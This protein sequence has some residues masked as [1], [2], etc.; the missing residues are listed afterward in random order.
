[1]AVHARGLVRGRGHD[2]VH[3]DVPH[4]VAIARMLLRLDLV[5][6]SNP[7]IQRSENSANDCNTNCLKR[8]KPHPTHGKTQGTGQGQHG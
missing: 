6:F 3:D 1:M 8:C 5:F 4:A 2:A 7:R